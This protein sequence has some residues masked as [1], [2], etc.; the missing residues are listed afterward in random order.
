MHLVVLKLASKHGAI[1]PPVHTSPRHLVVP[2]RSLVHV[3]IAVV[4]RAKAVLETVVPSPLV[5]L[6][7]RKR[8]DVKRALATHAPVKDAYL[9]DV[10]VGFIRSELA[11]ALSTALPQLPPAST[12]TTPARAEHANHGL[13]NAVT[14]RTCMCSFRSGRSTGSLVACHRT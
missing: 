14:V 7:E 11:F 1:A 10:I 4:S 6:H 9:E 3:P 5:E 13:Y 2:P 8:V 12:S